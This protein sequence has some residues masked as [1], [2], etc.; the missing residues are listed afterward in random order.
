HAFHS[1]LMDPILDEFAASVGDLVPGTLSIPVVSTR[2]GREATLAELTSVEHW[3]SHIRQPVRFFDAVEQARVAGANAFFE[4]GPGATLASITTDAFAGEGIDDVVVVSASRR[5]REPVDALAAA[6]AQWHARGGAVNW[7]AVF[8]GRDGRGVDL[9]TYAF[10]HQRYWLD[11]WDGTTGADVSSAGLS[12]PDHPLLGAVVEHPGT[13]EFVFTGLWS[14]QSREW[15]ADHAVYG[16]VVVPATAYL[17]LALWVGEYVGSPAIEELSLEVPLILPSTG[18]VRVR[19]AV[20]A[21][22]EEGRRTLDVYSEAGDGWV[23]HAA[24]TLVPS[25]SSDP[26][27]L[28]TWPPAGAKQLAFDGLYETLADGGFA[29]GPMFQGLREVWQRGDELFGQATLPADAD[30]AYVLH[31]ALLDSLLHTVVVGK[32]IEV[33][34]DQGWMPFSWAGVELTA[35]A[36]STVR[37]RITSAAEGV[38]S[39]TIADETGREIGHIDTLTFRPASAAQVGSARGSS[40]STPFQVQWRAIDKRETYRGHWARYDSLADVPDPAPEHLV[41]RLDDPGDDT[42]LL[43][44]VTAADLRVL[45][46]VRQFLADERFAE[47]TLVLVTRH[48]IDTGGEGVESLLGASAWGLLRSA[49]TEHPGRFRLVDIDDE[50]SSWARLPDTFVL[51]ED[52][53]AI[54][55][56]AVRAPSLAAST[57]DTNQIEPPTDGTYRLGI[58]SKGTLE[59]LTWVP[60]PEVDEPLASGQVRIAVQAAGL[61]FRDVTIALGLVTRTA[62]DAGLGSEGAGIVTE[63]AG[64]VTGFAPGDRV[65]GVFSGAFGRVAVADHRLLAPIPDG[66]SYAEAASVPAVFLTAYYAL[67]RLRK[68]TKGQRVLIHAAAGGVGMAAVQLAQSAGAEIYG[69]ASPAKWS[70]LEGLGLDRDHLASSRDLEFVEKF[71]GTSNGRGVDFVLNSLAHEFVDASLRLLPAGGNFVEM[72]KTDIRDAGQVA[73]DH[74]GVDY[75]AFDLFAAGPE[76]IGELFTAVLK[77]FEEGRIRLN[78][79]SIWNI[80]DARTAFREMSRGR[81]VGKIVFELNDN[82]GGGTVLLTGGTGGVGSQVARHLVTERGVR[83]LVLASRSGPASEGA[84]ELVAELTGSGAFVDVV[85]CDVADP[86]A[87]EKVLS[88]LPGAYPLTAVVH[89]AGAL[90]DGTVESLTEDSFDRVLRAKV[91]GAINLHELT[92]GRNLSAFV[93]FSALAGTLGNG[94]QANYAAANGFLDGLAARRKADGL[95]GQSLCWGWWAQSSGM[96]EDLDQADMSRIRRMGIVG[97]STAEALALFDSARAIDAPVLVPAQFDTFALQNRADVPLPLRALVDGGRQRKAKVA[98]DDGQ[99]SFADRLANLSAADAETF[100]LDWVREQVAVVLGHAA[101][102]NIDVDQAFKYL[103]FDSLTSVELCNRLA[104]T[105]GLRL[106]STLVFSYPTPRLLGQH[107]A[108]KLITAP[109]AEPSDDGEIREILRTVPIENLRNAGLIELIRACANDSDGNSA[110]AD[111]DE[112]ADLDLDAL[113]DLVLDESGN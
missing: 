36:G 63:V 87:V 108:G 54:R 41:V 76:V 111:A 31:P 9:P 109:P 97:M 55:D 93:L 22:D 101:G 91:G 112:L 52:Q 110:I 20:R 29:Y 25:A 34:G 88:E 75:E 61:N 12:T 83:S 32:L 81:H 56:G 86:A 24:G 10:Q 96:A 73:A 7:D 33:V 107:I 72:G 1:P 106:P 70:T 30:G 47:S 48:A 13:N 4:V 80:R 100:V 60:C 102:T 53:L 69:T 49:Q 51:D 26:Q 74:P 82:F 46:W 78:P 95:V 40:E 38:M 16:M 43:A 19:L 66:W 11:F 90:A 98:R 64:D 5:D 65:M 104:A 15:L 3:Q 77:H 45:G 71:L 14:L 39:V 92:K 50:D 8:D 59:N 99:V 58:P 6:L 18:D 35:R 2:L 42:E 103:G 68:L 94:G 89:A 21:A 105:T 79:I 23:R 62:I 84:A 44:A 37:V 67:F 85:A 113:V 57:P 28:A 17:D 27:S